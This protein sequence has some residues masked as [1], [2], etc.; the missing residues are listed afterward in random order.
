MPRS[1]AL[2]AALDH[3]WARGAVITPQAVW[4][5]DP[6]DDILR[7]A[8]DAQVGWIL[9]GAHRAVFGNNFTG[10]V[11]HR[12]LDSVRQLPINVGVVI[13]SGDSSFP[14]VCAVADCSP[15]GLATVGLAARI[16]QQKDCELHA[17]IV[18]AEPALS[19]PDVSNDA[20]SGASQTLA[21]ML[22]YATRMV[23]QHL[24]PEILATL[25]SIQIAQQSK[26]SLVIIATSLADHLEYTGDGLGDGRAIVLVQGPEMA[27]A[28]APGDFH[29]H[30][31]QRKTG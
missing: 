4:S 3:A 10:G 18:L 23:G 13:H 19:G 9:L 14:R 24:Y 21:Q 27:I 26:N 8:A 1:L 7:T 12:I 29:Y 6:A 11:V 28:A 16:A 31:L 20:N 30:P 22:T 15:H 2:S 5:D 25:D 17:F